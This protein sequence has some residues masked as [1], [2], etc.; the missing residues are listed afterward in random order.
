MR[1]LSASDPGIS[2]NELISK[3]K[4]SQPLGTV[5]RKEVRSCQAE[6]AR[7]AEEEVAAAARA[8]KAKAEAAAN[9]NKRYRRIGQEVEKARASMQ[10]E[11]AAKEAVVAEA[12]AAQTK[13]RA[14]VRPSREMEERLVKSAEAA[15][16]KLDLEALREARTQ[17]KDDDGHA[18]SPPLGPG[19]DV[20]EEANEA[21]IKYTPPVSSSVDVGNLAAYYKSTSN[22][23]NSIF[24]QHY[25]ATKQGADPALQM[26]QELMG[27]MGDDLL[28]QHPQL[29]RARV[30]P[31]MGHRET[32]ASPESVT[33]KLADALG[34]GTIDASIL[35]HKPG[36]LAVKEFTNAADRVDELKNR[37]S[38]DLS[39]LQLSAQQS[40]DDEPLDIVL[41]DDS[42]S[43]GCTTNE[44][45]RTI[46]EEAVAIG[47]R[48]KVWVV[49]LAQG[50]H[51][52][53]CDALSRSP[54]WLNLHLPEEIHREIERAVDTS[55]TDQPVAA[56]KEP[57]ERFRGA[58]YVKF[59][60][61]AAGNVVGVYGGSSARKSYMGKRFEKIVR[62][63]DSE[64]ESHICRGGPSLTAERALCLAPAQWRLASLHHDGP[65]REPA[66][67]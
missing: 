48:V 6:L 57:A 8:A 26:A 20:A 56:G 64:H 16:C 32:H 5:G 7:E 54:L 52:G 65:P 31:V 46:K 59:A 33:Y 55:A 28:D 40:D 2:L 15:G 62:T 63:R 47:L 12:P 13:G 18:P 53:E 29:D 17:R 61:D 51:H 44:I 60:T 1:E 45:A 42:S 39:S 19:E 21:W 67:R 14:V 22:G 34:F 23:G 9:E 49:V 27:N 41:V 3:L 10:A 30:I 11:P 66:G 24:S 36:R 38:A 50:V 25:S 4:I 58:L 37:Y 35:T 43:H